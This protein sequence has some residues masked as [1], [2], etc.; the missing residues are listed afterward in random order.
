VLRGQLTKLLQDGYVQYIPQGNLEQA[1]D[2]CCGFTSSA[3]EGSMFF[4]M[5]GFR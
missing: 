4:S 2:F 3:G 5:A 1:L